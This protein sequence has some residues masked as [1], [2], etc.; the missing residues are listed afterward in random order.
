MR[1]LP[2]ACA[3]AYY[4]RSLPG[5]LAADEGVM[6]TRLM[7]GLTKAVHHAAARGAHVISISLGGAVPSIALHNAMRDAEEQGVIVLC[8]A[9]NQV[10]FVVF[11]AAFDE[12][13]AVAASTMDDQHWAGSCRGPAVDITAPGSSVWR[14]RTERRCGA[15]ARRAGHG[16]SPA[17]WRPQRAAGLCRPRCRRDH[18]R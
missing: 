6:K 11:P 1:L 14:A 17:A 4:R 16:R 13:I 7:S 18:D 15:H 8:A 2:C 3:R 9:G 5:L 12:V 10:G